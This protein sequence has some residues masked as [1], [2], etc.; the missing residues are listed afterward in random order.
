MVSIQPPV[1]M[2]TVQNQTQWHNIQGIPLAATL[3]LLQAA[4]PRTHT[5]HLHSPSLLHTRTISLTIRRTK[6]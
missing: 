5:P 3:I 2:S 4:A 1:F 6:V